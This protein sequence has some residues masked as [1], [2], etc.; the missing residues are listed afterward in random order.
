MYTYLYTFSLFIIIILE[1]TA[2]WFD[3]ATQLLK[4][5]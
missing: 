1:D 3:G 4:S 5:R 2:Y